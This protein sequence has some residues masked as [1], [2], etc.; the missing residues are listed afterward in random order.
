MAQTWP[1][2]SGSVPICVLALQLRGGDE[3]LD[4]VLADAVAELRVAELGAADALLL[5][6]DPPAAL[7]RQP[8]RPLEVLVG[9]RLARRSG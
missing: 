7:Q 9:D 1:G 3:L 4:A 5:L 8:D 2:G 6:L